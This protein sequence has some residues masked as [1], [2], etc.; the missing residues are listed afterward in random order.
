MDISPRTDDFA[1]RDEAGMAVIGHSFK[2][3]ASSIY[4]GSNET[5]R[6]VVANRIMPGL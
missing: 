1:C 4:G 3:S 6:T 2:T 5:Q